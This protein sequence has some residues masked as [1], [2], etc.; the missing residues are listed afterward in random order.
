MIIVK[1]DHLAQRTRGNTESKSNLLM[2]D[3]PNF[4]YFHL[5]YLGYGDLG[6]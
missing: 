1:K 3:K 2:V 5:E 6:C 4:I